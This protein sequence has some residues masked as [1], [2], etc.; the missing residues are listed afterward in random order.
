MY[1]IERQPLTA[2]MLITGTLAEPWTGGS[3]AEVEWS[4]T[5]WAVGAECIRASLHRVYKCAVARTASNTTPPESDPTAWVEQRPTARWVPFGPYT[6]AAGQTVYRGHAVES[7][8]TDLVWRLQ[9]R[10]CNALALFGLRGARVR[11]QVYSTVG[12]SL[13]YTKVITL[14]RP[15]SGYWDYAYGQKL[16]RDRLLITGL[17]IYP[18]AEVVVTVEGATGQQRRITQLEYGKL[19]YLPGA[20]F[21]GVGYGVTSNVRVRMFR[22]QDDDGT[23][24]VLLWGTS[25]DLQGNV[26]IAADRENAVLSLLRSVVGKGVACAPSLDGDAEQRLV[27]GVVD[28]APVKRDSF[29]MASVDMTLRGL[30]VD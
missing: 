30:P 15:A 29:G 2:S 12:G 20:S 13:V 23:E 5:T 24:A 16:N 6:N 3:T 17:P 22:R 9:L 14:K 18:A 7:T 19:R 25:Q 21:G 11:V 10:Y 28:A 1:L 26:T 27:F 4:A 8:T